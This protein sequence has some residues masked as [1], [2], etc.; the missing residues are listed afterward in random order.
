MKIFFIIA[1]G[2]AIGALTRQFVASQVIRIAGDSFPWQTLFIN[3]LGSFF[4]GIIFELIAS[5]WNFQNE[6]KVFITIGVLSSFTTFSSFSLDIII[7]LERGQ[8]YPAI[9]Y[10][11]TSVFFSVLCLF[12]GMYFVRLIIV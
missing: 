10:I 5:K 2:G 4:M 9:G 12:C 11:L 1:L 3:I 8:I 6:L 7:L